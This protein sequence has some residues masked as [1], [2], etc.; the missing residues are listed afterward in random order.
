MYFELSTCIARPV[1]VVFSF[2]R[3][4]HKLT[5]E[6]DSSVQ[7]I[8]KTTS[9]PVGKGTCYLEVVRILPFYRETIISEITVYEPEKL[10][11]EC[12]E[13]SMMKGRLTYRFI[14]DVN[15]TRLTQQEDLWMRG[16]MVPF[17]PLI[18]RTFSSKLKKRL[19]GIRKILESGWT[20]ID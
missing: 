7:I 20:T 6:K 10:I 1:P 4:K 12:F 15:K 16:L 18:R 9:G 5:Q 3:D 14:A 17:Q 19:D 8:E 2:F 11:E 13:S